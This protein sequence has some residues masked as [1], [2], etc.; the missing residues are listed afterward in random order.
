MPRSLLLANGLGTSLAPAGK[1]HGAGL[2]GPLAVAVLV[3]VLAGERVQA[4][5]RNICGVLT[6]P[7]ITHENI[8]K[9]ER[10]HQ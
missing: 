3:S 5:H 9:E 7:V 1:P 6:V 2:S 10:C 4:Q 8:R